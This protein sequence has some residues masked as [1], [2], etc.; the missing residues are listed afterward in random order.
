MIFIECKPDLALVRTITKVTRKEIA[1]EFKGKGG[2]CAQLRYRNNC[3][4]LVD[5]DP[6]SPQPRFIQEA[7]LKED[8]SQH[9]IKVLHH[10]SSDNYILLL[11]PRL[12]EWVLK[13]AKEASVDVGKYG[14]PGDAA[15]L[16]GVININL[17]KFEKLLDDL[18]DVDRLRK[19]KTVMV[20]MLRRR[21]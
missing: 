9:D 5:E 11:C 4:G 1:H 2:V 10:G 12:E 17:D 14:L 8:L 15:R 21:S 16:H 20:G 3:I 19:L 6:S 18:K 7:E 13:A